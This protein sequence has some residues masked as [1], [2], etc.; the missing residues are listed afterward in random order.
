MLIKVHHAQITIP[1]GEEKKAREFYVDFLGLLEI[2]K[3]ES[4]QN[5]G[6]FWMELSGFQI[7]VGT[8]EAFDRTKTKAHIAYEVNDLENWREKLEHRGVKIL[9]GIPIPGYSRFEFRDPVRKSR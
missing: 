5:R 9:D 6:G 3:P 7:H 8:E 1:T 4:L 2:L